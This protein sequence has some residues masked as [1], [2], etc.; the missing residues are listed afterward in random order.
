[1]FTSRAEYRLLLR[2]D[3]ADLRL[4]DRGREI[5]LV[6]DHRY[7]LFS[8]KKMELEK[9]WEILNQTIIYPN[10]ETNQTL[11][12]LGSPSLKKGV[13]LKELL[14]RPE[15][16]WEDLYPLSPLLTE[17]PA[18]VMGQL[19]IQAKYE[20]YLERQEQEVKRLEKIEFTPIPHDLDYS[21]LSGLSNEIKEKLKT[22]RPQSL[23][24]ASR[25][26]GV[27]PA[28]LAILQIHI[29]KRAT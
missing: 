22:I 18:S 11:A 13:P 29:K 23:G 21:T 24:Q 28:A 17:I 16:H 20:G 15:L 8:W 7:D 2:E 9:G 27:T 1:M 10:V 3:N 12:T 6:D 4:T 26:S 5:G 19:A 14:R 25:I